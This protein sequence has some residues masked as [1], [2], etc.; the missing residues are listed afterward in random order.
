MSAN[1]VAEDSEQHNIVQLYKKVDEL[2]QR[3]RYIENFLARTFNVRADQSVSSERTE[4]GMGAI[5][6]PDNTPFI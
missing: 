3:V 6:N 4:V 2:E 1:S 5:I